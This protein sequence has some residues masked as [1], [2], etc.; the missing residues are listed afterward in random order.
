[1]KMDQNSLT[2]SS[3]LTLPRLL[4]CGL[5]I[6]PLFYFVRVILV[7]RDIIYV[8]IILYLWHLAICENFMSVCVE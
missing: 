8:V 2:R 7:F 5:W 3:S 1:M 6:L 4:S